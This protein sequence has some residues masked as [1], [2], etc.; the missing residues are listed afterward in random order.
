MYGVVAKLAHKVPQART[1]EDVAGLLKFLE[2]RIGLD[3]VAINH[4]SNAQE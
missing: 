4:E 1:I 3:K 2:D